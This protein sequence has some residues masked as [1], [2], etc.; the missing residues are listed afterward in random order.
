MSAAAVSRVFE[1]SKQKGAARLLAVGLAMSLDQDGVCCPDHGHL[2]AR[3][4]VSPDKLERLLR[5]LLASGEFALV[6]GAG[7]GGR[8]RYRMCLE[9][10]A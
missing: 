7:P 8:P 3:C 9:A 1:H 5:E 6:D 2:A 10:T 4:S